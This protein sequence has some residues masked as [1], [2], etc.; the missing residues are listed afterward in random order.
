MTT[1]IERLLGEIAAELD[2][3]RIALEHIAR[4]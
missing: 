3:I 4:K 1:E 2:R